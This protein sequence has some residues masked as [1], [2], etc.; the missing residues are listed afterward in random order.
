MMVQALDGYSQA[1]QIDAS[2]GRNIV[3]G[4][5]HREEFWRLEFFQVG[6][7]SKFEN[8]ISLAMFSA[9]LFIREN[10]YLFYIV[11]MVSFFSHS[12]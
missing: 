3:Q 12:L 7:P 6:L 1:I 2:K 9:H 11:V 10:L 8:C 4:R 5:K